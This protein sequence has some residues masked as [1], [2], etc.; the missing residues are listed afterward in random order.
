MTKKSRDAFTLIEVMISVVIISVVILALLE[1]QGNSTHIFSGLKK[2]LKM[3]Q[4]TSFFISNAEYGFEKKSVDMDE[5][6]SDFKVEDELRRELKN[7]KV[8][9]V[10][11]E[12][13]TIDLREFEQ[14]DADLSEGDM[15]ASDS[16]LI[17]EVGKTVLKTGD[18]TSGLMRLRFQ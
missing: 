2:Q 3:N 10:Y 1:M 18:S 13:N 6:V 8:E 4:Y 7:I 15:S 16:N 17:F 12:L 11:Q 14:S 5:L 9:L